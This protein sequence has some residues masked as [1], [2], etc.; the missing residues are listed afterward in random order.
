MLCFTNKSLRPPWP[1][2]GRKGRWS[3][4]P[5][6]PRNIQKGVMSQRGLLT[7]KGH[8]PNEDSPAEEVPLGQPR[9]DYTVCP[10]KTHYNQWPVKRNQDSITGPWPLPRALSW[11]CWTRVQVRMWNA[12][13]LLG[14]NEERFSQDP[15][16]VL[17]Y[18]HPWY[19]SITITLS[20]LK[21]IISPFI[22]WIQVRHKGLGGMREL[23]M[24]IFMWRN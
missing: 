10:H 6:R 13:S 21:V 3:G 17:K 12:V 19:R 9:L 4:E 5:Y 22:L 23:F 14:F 24:P 1:K 7:A 15:G 8:S 11:A 2:E 20:Y 16:P 18:G